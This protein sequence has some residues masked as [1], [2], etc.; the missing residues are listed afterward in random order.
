LK[1]EAEEAERQ[2]L[3]AVEREEMNAAL[4]EQ[5]RLN[6]ELDRK[7]AEEWKAQ[8][9]KDKIAAELRAAEQVERDK[10]AKELADLK[11]EKLEAERA[12]EI[13]EA[14]ER[15]DKERVAAA[16][17]EQARLE[18]IKPDIKKVQEFGARIGKLVPPSCES[19]EAQA[20]ILR[21][22]TDLYAIQRSLL[23]FGIK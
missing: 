9:E 18:A 7:L 23:A 2:A 6:A 13:R 5:K 12:R 14:A 22:K 3:I 15:A 11:F 8:A 16:E 19:E 10:I 1:A 4:E 20:V 21:T 17:R